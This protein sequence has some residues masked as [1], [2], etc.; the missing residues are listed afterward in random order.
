MK[1]FETF[2]QTLQS[3]KYGL[4]PDVTSS[5][6]AL[7]LLCDY[8]LGEDFVCGDSMGVDQGNTVIVYNILKKYSRKFNKD[9][10]KRLKKEE[11][12]LKRE[13]KCDAIR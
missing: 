10:K 11:R 1:N 3:D 2:Y 7:E 13:N 4:I 8:L 12:S 9:L 5:Q 6:F